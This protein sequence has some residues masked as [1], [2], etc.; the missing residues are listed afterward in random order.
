MASFVLIPGAGGAAWYWHRVAPLLEEAGHDALPIDLPADDEKAGLEAYARIVVNQ[1]ADRKDVVLVAQSL[2]A[3]TAAM[4]TDRV[5]VTRLVL[6]NAMIPLPGETADAWWKNTQ[7]EEARVAAAKAHHYS[8]EF[9]LETYFLHDVPEDVTRGGAEHQRP[10]AKIAFTEPCTFDEWPDVPILVLIGQ[11]DR[12]FPAA[13]QERI[14]RERLA[15]SRPRI[16][17][18]RGGHLIALSNPEQLTSRL[19]AFLTC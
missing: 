15:R 7:S 14:A 10:E 2:G 11:D 19:L 16:E 17:R 18:I 6:V 3:F 9:D 5:P 12:F 8:P 13:F 1:V 4:V